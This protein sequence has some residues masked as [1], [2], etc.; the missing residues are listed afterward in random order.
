[1][2]EKRQELELSL[3][4]GRLKRRKDGNHAHAMMMHMRLE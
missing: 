1:M 4:I 3:P 2:R